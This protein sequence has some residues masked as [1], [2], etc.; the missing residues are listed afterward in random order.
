MK[1]REGGLDASLAGFRSGRRASRANL[2][3]AAI[4]VICAVMVASCKSELYTNLDQRQANELVATLRQHGIPADRSA[5][6]GDRISVSVDESRFA[7]AEAVLKDNGLPKPE[8]VTIGEV[9]KRDGLVS[10]PVQER[11]QMS[12]ALSQELSRTVSEIDGVLSARVHVVLPENDP[13][14][15]QVVPASASVSIRHRADTPM[16]ELIPK[17]KELLQHSVPGLSS[18]NDVSVVLFPVPVQEAATRNDRAVELGALARGRSDNLFVADWPL[19]SA[20]ALALAF[21]GALAFVMWRDRPRVY[22]LRPDTDVNPP[23]DA[24]KSL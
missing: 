19:Y 15:Q 2:A 5:G 12:F 11:A 10:S 24:V 9:F 21:V 6:K 16:S 13:L 7:E 22:Q 1:S 18:Y 3:R 17:I 14:R 20:I 23:D 8:F 4:L